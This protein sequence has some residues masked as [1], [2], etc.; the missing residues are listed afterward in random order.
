VHPCPPFAPCSFYWSLA[1]VIYSTYAAKLV[2][3]LK[4]AENAQ[5]L[6]M[7]ASLIA[8]LLLSL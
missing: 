6:G 4:W 7:V 3:H 2:P 5:I 1:T 8:L